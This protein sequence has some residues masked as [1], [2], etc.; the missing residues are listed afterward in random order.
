MASVLTRQE[1]VEGK[2]TTL[3]R[4]LSEAAA[5]EFRWGKHDCC[6]FIGEWARRVTGQNPADP[7][8]DGYCSEAMADAI[9]A[10]GG[11]LGPVL[12][13]ALTAQGWAPVTGCAPGD[14]SVVNAPT[15][16]GRKLVA[17]IFAGRGRF[18]L[19]T[20][21]GLVVATLPFFLGWRHPNAR[22]HVYG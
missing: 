18:A 11:G 13:R 7:W 21:H 14:I 20:H 6:T 19:V 2:A 5:K 16:A 8:K 4:Y 17:S 22:A 9:L 1:F 15:P 12:H 3:Q 10:H